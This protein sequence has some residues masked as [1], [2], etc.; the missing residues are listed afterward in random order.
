[1]DAL[2]PS[3]AGH[4]GWEE[5]LMLNKTILLSAFFFPTLGLMAQQ[6]PAHS[7]AAS[8]WT[9]PHDTAVLD[10]GPRT[11]RF[12]VVYN[13]TSTIGQIVRRQRLTADYT[14]GLPGGQVEWNNVTAEDGSGDKAPYAAPQKSV[15]MDGFAY[16][17]DANTMA[18][19]FFKAFPASAYLERN[20]VWDTQMF[21][22]F[23]QKFFDKL[24]L[25][26]PF[27][28]ASDQD[29]NLPAMGNFRNHDLVLEWVGRSERNG[30][31]CALIE[32]RAFFN[33][34]QLA[35]GGMKMDARSDYWGEIWVSLSTRQIEY[36]TL[37]EEVT[38]QMKLP[39]QDAPMPLNVFRM[40]TFE[41]ASMANEGGAR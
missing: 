24:Q 28:A 22:M 40:G 11:Y 7:V 9:L 38:G 2:V 35:T 16:R 18:P 3:P 32:Y 8:V 6:T 33:P 25:N 30:Q 17:D 39:N 31:E 4:C 20:L 1:M 36:A 5:T 34:V 10:K 41:P 27:H 19:E 29:V 37:Y 21:E 12:T 15:F 13:T 14:R 23:G 26:R